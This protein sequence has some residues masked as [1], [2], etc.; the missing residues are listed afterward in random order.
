MP[1]SV[2]NPGKGAVKLTL[3]VELLKK[4][5][6]AA[7]NSESWKVGFAEPENMLASGRDLLGPAIADTKEPR[8]LFR[9]DVTVGTTEMGGANPGHAS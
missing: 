2:D 4:S 8:V 7:L 6:P 9:A 3:K 5:R 1:R